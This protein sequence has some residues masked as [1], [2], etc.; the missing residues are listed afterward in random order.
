VRKVVLIN[1]DVMSRKVS[2]KDRN[3]YP[4]IGDGAS[5]AIIERSDDDALIHANLK[6]DGTRRER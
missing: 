3:S 5:V 4:L 2:T 6:M 1:V